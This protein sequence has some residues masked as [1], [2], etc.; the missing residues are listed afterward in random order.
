MTDTN[1]RPD[2]TQ[3]PGPKYLALSRALRDAVRDGVLTAG[4][5]LPTVRDLA[6]KLEI[7]P[8]TV[9]RAYQLA[10][11]E[12]L[13]AATVGRGTFVA[14]TTPQLGPTQ[15]LFVESA[16]I[17]QGVVDLRSP[18]L[19]H[20]GQAG[21]IRAAFHALADRIEDDY[22]DYPTQVAETDLRQA[23]VQWVADRRMGPVEEEDVA[24]THGG[25]AAINLIM[26][27]CLRGDRPV[28]LAEDLAYP[29]FRHAARL[30]RA[31]TVGVELDQHGLRPDAL[32]AA[33]RR[34]KAQILCV[35]T[36]AQNPTAARMPEHR[37]SEIA[38]IARA[39][40]LQVIED[41][42]Y[43]VSESAYPMIRAHVPERT[44]YVGSWSKSVSAALRFGYV[45]CP[46]GMGTAGRMTAQHVS[47]AMPRPISELALE[48]LQN[49]T[50]HT[51]RQRS[52]AEFAERL[53]LMVRALDGQDI[54]WQPGLPFVWL[55]LPA[56]WRASTFARMAQAAGILV[57]S[58]DEYALVHGHA[59]NAVRLA[60][61]GA[62]PRERFEQAMHQIRDL[63]LSPPAELIV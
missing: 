28:V 58:A 18:S 53:D 10:T 2:L 9:S 41:D 32:E 6:W 23:V 37:R 4:A 61:A 52:Q 36:E 59:P 51:L 47:F 56:G 27:C 30:S 29:G 33:C 35:T 17:A 16:L 39:Y 15:P 40:D 1:W 50:A 22:V 13:L 60:V 45:I 48:L 31:E 12:G 44:W 57:R 38:L 55:R 20:L 3:Y 21:A 34:H 11:Q 7:T 25:Q 54:A 5:Q 62:V 49:G 24:L 46:R 14:A 63:L 26:N 43:S 19:P 42:C 8:G